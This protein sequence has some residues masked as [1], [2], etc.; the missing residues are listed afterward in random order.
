MTLTLE[1]QP[2][3]PLVVGADMSRA[4]LVRDI[5]LTLLMWLLFA[6]LAFGELDRVAG[7]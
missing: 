6:L 2:W 3:P 5:A 7:Q 4:I 1:N